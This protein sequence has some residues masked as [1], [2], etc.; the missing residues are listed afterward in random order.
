[1]FFVERC[2]VIAQVSA[3]HCDCCTTSSSSNSCWQGKGK[4]GDGDP[5]K[6]SQEEN[7]VDYRN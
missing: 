2:I 1:M 6:R 3:R 7:G 4:A 5:C